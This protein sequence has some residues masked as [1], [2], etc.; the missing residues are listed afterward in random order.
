M[1]KWLTN[2]SDIE[3]S[4]CTKNGTKCKYNYQSIKVCVYNKNPYNIK[5]MLNLKVTHLITCG[6]V[7]LTYGR[8]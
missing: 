3:N 6:T 1:C 8:S 7:I 5:T 2:D 4:M